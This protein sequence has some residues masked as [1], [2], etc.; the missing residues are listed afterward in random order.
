LVKATPGAAG[1]ASV[2]RNRFVVASVLGQSDTV[3]IVLDQMLKLQSVPQQQAARGTI[4][5][6]EVISGKL[7]RAVAT[8]AEQA[9]IQGARDGQPQ[10]TGIPEAAFDIQFRGHAAEGVQKLDAVVAGPQWAASDPVDRPYLRVATFYARAARPDKAR[11]LLARYQSESAAEAKAPASKQ[12]IAELMGEIALAE[13]KADEAVKQFR[14]ADIEED[15]GLTVC[16]GCTYFNLGRAFDKAGQTD[17]VT[18]YYERYLALP[19]APLRR[20]NNDGQALAM[21]QKR[22]GEIYDSKN[23]RQK[24]LANYGAF[25]EQWKAADADLQPAV[26]SV[27]KRIAELQVKEGK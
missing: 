9:A 8:N 5:G 18:A 11:Q 4:F 26:T 14:A 10:I 17:S 7:S 15:G 24:A 23:E 3:Q 12:P 16:E 20:L 25:V 19:A 22:L 27:K 2:L 21:I 6:E 13:G 1:L